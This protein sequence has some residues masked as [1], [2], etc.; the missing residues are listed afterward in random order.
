MNTFLRRASAYSHRAALETIVRPIAEIEPLD[1]SGRKHNSAC[2]LDPERTICV[3]RGFVS[4]SK[5]PPIEIFENPDHGYRFRLRDG[6]HRFYASIAAG[7]HEIPTVIQPRPFI[8]ETETV[9][10]I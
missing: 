10:A 9:L 6:A 5:L 8:F 7:Y 4:G 2:G 3:L 1:M